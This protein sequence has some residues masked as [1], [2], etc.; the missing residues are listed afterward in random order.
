VC[1]VPLVP[2]NLLEKV[3]SISEFRD[4]AEAPSFIIPECLL[5]GNDILMTHRSQQ[6]NL[7]QC[8]LL[9]LV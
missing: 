2:D 4:D 5:V 8:I 1:L 6:S 3:S 7:I 9:L